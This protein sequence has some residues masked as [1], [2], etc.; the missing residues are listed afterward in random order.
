MIIENLEISSLCNMDCDYCGRKYITR[1]KGIMSLEMID[2]IGR[3]IKGKQKIVWLHG[4]GEPLTHPYLKEV[5]YILKSYGV[6]SCFY[7]NGN[8]LTE[9]MVDMLSKS[10][11][12]TICVTMNNCTKENL[13][14]KLIK[15]CKFQVKKVWVNI[16]TSPKKE[17]C[18]EEYSNPLWGTKK[19]CFYQNGKECQFRKDGKV[20][21]TSNG[22]VTTCV[23]DY[24]Y[25][26]SKVLDF[27]CPFI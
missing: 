7:T 17:Y 26:T 13:V 27:N 10:P 23:K 25:F 24:D 3:K 2:K 12:K 4:W 16:T 11:I 22:R 1:E 21:I 19:K 14:D 15:K 5:M 18:I 8:L 6:N 20:N 9:E